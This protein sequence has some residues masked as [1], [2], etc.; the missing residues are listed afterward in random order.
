MVMRTEES[1][2]VFGPQETIFCCGRDL[3]FKDFVSKKSDMMWNPISKKWEETFHYHCPSCGG[4]VAYK[5]GCDY[6]I[7]RVKGEVLP[8]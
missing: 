3:S 2:T 4:V 7:Q 6:S 1:F 8:D 5:R